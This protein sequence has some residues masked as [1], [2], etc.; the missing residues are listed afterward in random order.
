MANKGAIG[1]TGAGSEKANDSSDQAKNL[2]LA[3][4]L[5]SLHSAELKWNLLGCLSA[6]KPSQIVYDSRSLYDF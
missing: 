2:F 6:V 4:G 3:S 1:N 5:H